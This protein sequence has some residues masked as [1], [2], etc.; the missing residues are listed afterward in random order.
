M[1]SLKQRFAKVNFEGIAIG[2]VLV[3]IGI[4]FLA[5]PADSMRIVCYVLGA[6]LIAVALVMLIAF[7]VKGA[8]GAGSLAVVAVVFTLGVLF[9]ARQGLMQTVITLVMGITF[10]ADGFSKLQE[11]IRLARSKRNLWGLLFVET[12]AYSVI[13]ILVLVEPW[14][15]GKT[16]GYFLGGGLIAV[17]LLDVVTALLLGKTKTTPLSPDKEL[18]EDE[19]Q[20][21]EEANEQTEEKGKKADKKADKKAEKKAEKNA[22][23]KEEQK[24]LPAAKDA[25]E[26]GDGAHEAEAPSQETK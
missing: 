22:E 18:K 26:E 8:K 7:F 25:E 21:E 23:E 9:L 10:I 19:P 5:F 24:A 11:M 4:L 15:A 13:G 3:I 17:G 20:P 14:G 6:A 1:K 2:L 12:I 16:L